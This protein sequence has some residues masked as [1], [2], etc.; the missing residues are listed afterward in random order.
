MKLLGPILAIVGI[1]VVV[2]ALVQHFVTPILGT[3]IPR[4]SLYVGILG[5]IVLVVGG[6]LTMSSMRSSS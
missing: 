2:L 4:L 6:Y 1:L 3:S 5:L